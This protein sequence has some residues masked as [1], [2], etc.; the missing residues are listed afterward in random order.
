VT[1]AR[2]DEARRA[3][4]RSRLIDEVRMPPDLV[5]VWIVAWEVEAADRGIERHPRAFWDGARDWIL[6]S[7]GRRSP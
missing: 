5:D 1:P 2:I 4:T 6:R 7:R 3:A